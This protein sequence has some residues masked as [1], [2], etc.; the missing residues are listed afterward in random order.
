METW[1]VHLDVDDASHDE[2]EDL[3]SLIHYD[4][5]HLGP[6]TRLDGNTLAVDFRVTAT[7]SGS[8]YSYIERRVGQLAARYSASRDVDLRVLSLLP[9]R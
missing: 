2:L 9:G 6:V 4:L 3:T 1:T 8:A 7:S 5:G